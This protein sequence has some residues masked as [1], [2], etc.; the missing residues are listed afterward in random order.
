[1][2]YIDPVTGDFMPQRPQENVVV[3]S[4]ART[5]TIVENIS[6]FVERFVFLRDSSEYL[7]LAAWILATYMCQKFD[8]TGYVFAYSPEPQSG[9]TTLLEVLNLLVANPG[10]IEIA[11]TQATLF[12]T[13]ATH[14]QLLDEIDGWTNADDLR[15]V[16]NAGYKRGGSVTRNEKNVKGGFTP[17]RYFV[18]GPRA[19]AGIGINTL[20]R[21]T[22]DR[23]FAFSM[24]RQKQGE[25]RERLR[26]RLVSTEVDSLRKEISDWVGGNA[27]VVIQQYEGGFAYLDQF[28]DRTI[29]ISEPLAA[30]VETA[31]AGY[32]KLDKSRESLLR[33]IRI[34]RQEQQSPTPEHRLL[35]ALLQLAEA[36]DPIVGN[37]SEIAAMLSNLADPPTAET[38]THVLRKYGFTTKS[39]RKAGEDGPRYRYALSRESLMDMV[40]RWVRHPNKPDHQ[41]KENEN[42][43]TQVVVESRRSV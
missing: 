8:Y 42:A 35:E 10:G 13:A 41:L 23:T 25:R 40:E 15:S 36:E 4:K 29:D 17:Q 1:M 20:D 28:S 2:S 21:T 7:L 3:R 32:E 33:A 39:V 6:A 27:E 9:K 14:T 18:Y 31:Y 11:P 37:A 16:L 24:V 38:V 5:T 26:L 19:L 12:R 43:A 34:T 30:I 22:R